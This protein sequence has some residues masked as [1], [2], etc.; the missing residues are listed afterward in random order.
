MKLDTYDRIELT[1]PW[2]GFGFQARHMWTPEGFTLYPEQ[3]RWWSLTCNMAREYQLLLE[4]E[5]LARKSVDSG[6][7]PQAVV[8]MVQALQ[9]RR[10]G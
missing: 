6:A 9:Q 10:R 2:A 3:M 8:R 4:Q 1:G 5:R 7:D